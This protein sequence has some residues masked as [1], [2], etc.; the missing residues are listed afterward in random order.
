MYPWFGVQQRKNSL[1]GRQ[2]DLELASEGGDTGEQNPEQAQAL[3]EEKPGPGCNGVVQYIQS[4][5]VDYNGQSQVANEREHGEDRF[6]EEVRT[7]I[8]EV[9]LAVDTLKLIIHAL[10]LA[11]RLGDDDTAQN[12][13]D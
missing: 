8:H 6:V 10:F 7:Q 13:L 3:Y 11:I 4:S 12:L 5:E 9:R 2:S 1:T